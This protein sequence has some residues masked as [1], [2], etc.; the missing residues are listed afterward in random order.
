MNKFLKSLMFLLV[1][2]LVF[3]A[4]LAL[5]GCGATPS[6]EVKAVFFDS[7][8]Y[9]EETGL[10]V[11]EVDVNKSKHLDYKVNPSTWS[12]YEV[13][14]STKEST[15]E[16]NLNYYL[17]D[18]GDIIV[19]SRE[20][21]DIKVEIRIGSCTDICIVRLK[22]YPNS[23]F[24]YDELGDRQQEI[25]VVVNS[26]SVYTMA[27]YG[28][29]VKPN[30]TTYVAELKESDF[31]FVVTSSDETVVSIP[32][33]SRLKFE[34]VATRVSSAVVTINMIDTTG[35]ILFSNKV[36]VSV[37]MHAGKSLTLLDCYKKFIKNG[38]SI[39]INDAEVD[40]NNKLT[41]EFK[42]YA[43]DKDGGYIE[44]QNLKFYCF[45][46]D[47]QYIDIDN[48]NNLLIINKPTQGTITFK[49]RMV[50]NLITD[51]SG[52]YEINFNVTI[53]FKM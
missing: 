30:L 24:L 11:F 8:I 40:E 18:S 13:F 41:L 39:T 28:E 47:V 7:D 16:N 34:A 20:F 22:K 52:V 37:V 1:I 43:F 19:V 32:D 53:N 36:N 26:E 17:E 51:D 49:V 27:P 21:L 15:E 33:S 25:S 29:F 2:A 48:S 45:V 38:D 50:S 3:P 10:A 42:N 46:D 14:F 35:T 23:M 9:D 31:S 6:N 4:V 44:N 5:T 12:G